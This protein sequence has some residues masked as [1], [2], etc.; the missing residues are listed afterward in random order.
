[1]S[2]RSRSQRVVLL[3]DSHC[4]SHTSNLDVG[5][6]ASQNNVILIVLPSHCMHHLQPLHISFFRSLNI[7]YNTK[8][9]AWL[10][11]HPGRCV[12]EYEIG[13]L[14]SCAH[15]KVASVNNATNGFKNAGIHLFCDDLFTEE[16]FWVNVFCCILVLNEFT[17]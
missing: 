13:G 3:M 7:N 14:F 2:P 5:Q 11:N 1:V 10:R 9:T 8:V 12:T 16:H 15:G 6:M 4:C 17:S